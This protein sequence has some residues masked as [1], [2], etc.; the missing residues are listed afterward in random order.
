MPRTPKNNA[1]ATLQSHQ[2]NG[3]RLAPR[4]I[5]KNRVHPYSK[6][7]PG[8]ANGAGW[9][10][11]DIC[12]AY[13]W[14][15]PKDVAG[16]G[17][18]A[19]IHLAGGWLATDVE[20]FFHDQG[21][22][23]TQRPDVS[24]HLSVGGEAPGDPSD[25]PTDPDLEVALDIQIA[26]ASYAVATQNPAKIRVY[27]GAQNAEGLIAAVR[28]AM[29]DECDVCCITWGKDERSWDTAD[30]AAFNNAAKA[31]VDNGMI[32]VAASGDNN[33]SDGGPT[34]ANVDFP[35]S[36][37]YVIGCGGTKLFH[38]QRRTRGVSSSNGMRKSGT[39]LRGLRPVAG[40]EAA[41]PNSS[42]YQIGNSEPS[43]H[44]C[45]WFRTS[46]LMR[47]LRQATGS[48]SAASPT[49]AAGRAPRRRS[50]RA[51]SPPSAQSVAS[52]RLNCTKTKSASTTSGVGTTACSGPWSAPIP[53][54][55]SVRRE[56]IVWRSASEAAMPR[57]QG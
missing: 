24:E 49:S 8:A 19:V 40:V 37:P 27:R 55:G 50:T 31:A 9:T 56:L 25:P 42:Q 38:Q 36:S 29:T 4:A 26:A 43:K 53:A 30:V 6:Q 10:V 3:R 48:L 17:T 28:A 16:G 39:T 47:T 1:S 54:L 18:I 2:T 41:F 21:L 51:C 12:A 13:N 45:E 52:S 46:P 32:I 33:S 57:L 14:P 22:D 35:A 7:P 34:P 44:E 15:K 23:G 20:K 11:P 5:S